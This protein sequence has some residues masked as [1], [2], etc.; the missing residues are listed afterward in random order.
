MGRS[1]NVMPPTNLLLFWD[2]VDLLTGYLGPGGL[3]LPLPRGR[4]IT[5]RQ[6]AV[7]HVNWRRFTQLALMD[8]KRAHTTFTHG[9]SCDCHW[10]PLGS[11]C[12]RRC[13]STRS[14]SLPGTFRPLHFHLHPPSPFRARIQFLLRMRGL[15][16]HPYHCTMV[17][18]GRMFTAL[19]QDV[20]R[21]DGWTVGSEPSPLHSELL[22]GLPY[23]HAPLYHTASTRLDI[24]RLIWLAF[25]T[26]A[27]GR[28]FHLHAP[29]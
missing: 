24:L 6:N 9:S 14:R 7:C 1:P 18:V 10:F 4:N 19:G 15:V 26:D 3:A 12:F 20:D 21:T 23:S 25:R 22:A 28:G 2:D 5:T 16:V 29:A 13:G 27:F 11:T 17:D 8:C